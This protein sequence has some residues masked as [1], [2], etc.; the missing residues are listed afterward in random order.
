MMIVHSPSFSWASRQ[1]RVNNS[2]KRLKSKFCGTIV[3]SNCPLTRRKA[4]WNSIKWP[5][6]YKAGIV[7]VGGLFTTE[8]LF[9]NIRQF[10]TDHNVKHNFIQIQ[11]L[12]KA[13]PPEWCSLIRSQRNGPHSGCPSNITLKFKDDSSINVLVSTTKCIYD[14]MVLSRYVKPTA[15]TRW[16]EAFNLSED[17]WKNIIR[18][19][20]S[21]SRE[22]KLQ[23]LQYK[24]IHR[25]LP[26]KKWLHTFTNGFTLW[27]IQGARND[28]SVTL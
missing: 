20:D 19:S 3:L 6:V 21:A 24:I 17:N 9:I 10:C 22:T 7:N 16:T 27:E 18:L 25:I 2:C 15:V 12:K 13:I 14:A 8:G 26:C 5:E 28:L 1:V 4:L 11:R 23:S